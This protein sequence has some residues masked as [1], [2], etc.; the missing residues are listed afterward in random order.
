MVGKRKG[1]DVI[2]TRKLNPQT[3]IE[4]FAREDGL[5]SFRE[6]KIVNNAPAAFDI[7]VYESGLYSD[8]KEIVLAVSHHI[9]TIGQRGQ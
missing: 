7:P 8:M 6:M 5:F 1:P 4:V 3:R 9:E 2:W